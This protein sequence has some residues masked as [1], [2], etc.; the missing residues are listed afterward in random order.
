MYIDSRVINKITVNSRFPIPKLDDMLDKMSGSTWFSKID[1]RLG[2]YQLRIKPGNER[3]TAFKPPNGLFKWL[4]M[5]FGL[6]NAPNTFMR[7]MTHILCLFLGKCLGV[8]FDDI[9][10]YNP[11]REE[12]LKHLWLVLEVLRP[13]KLYINLAKCSFLQSEAVFLGFVVSAKGIN[14][15][16]FRKV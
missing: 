14:F 11:S 1:L 4:V 7:A 9:L 6:T 10:I 8:Y 13:Q 2:Y 5:P 12:H 16:Q 3:K 15:C